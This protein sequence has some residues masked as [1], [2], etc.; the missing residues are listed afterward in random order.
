[1]LED[2][3]GCKSVTRLVERTRD[4]PAVSLLHIFIA[5][6]SSLPGRA[7]ELTS[8]DKRGGGATSNYTFGG[9]TSQHPRAPT[10]GVQMTNSD[11]SA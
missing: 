6:V 9:G 1:M 2:I 8:H 4:L 3:N 7:P 10:S 5:G 11:G